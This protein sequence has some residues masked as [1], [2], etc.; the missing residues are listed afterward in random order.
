MFCSHS[1]QKFTKELGLE[2]KMTDY[3]WMKVIG[4]AVFAIGTVATAL[5]VGAK[6]MNKS[7]K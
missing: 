6:T 7:K 2:T 4:G 1:M 5:L 3:Q